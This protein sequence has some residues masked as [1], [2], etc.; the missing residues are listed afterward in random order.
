M[1]ILTAGLSEQTRGLC[2]LQCN[3]STQVHIEPL[4]N[5]TPF[6]M[7]RGV[8]KCHESRG[9]WCENN[10]ARGAPA[11]RA[12]PPRQKK[13]HIHPA[14]SA[15]FGFALRK[16]RAQMRFSHEEPRESVEHAVKGSLIYPKQRLRRPFRVLPSRQHLGLQRTVSIVLQTPGSMARGWHC[17]SPISYCAFAVVTPRST[18]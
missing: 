12:D 15:A 17:T 2:S 3:R 13:G 16:L 6:A 8:H 11:G 4:A 5:P 14:Q 7:H 1:H 9:L 10:L 18:S